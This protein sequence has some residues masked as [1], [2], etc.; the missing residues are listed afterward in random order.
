[1]KSTN[2]PRF[3]RWGLYALAFFLGTFLL[4][5][6]K[7]LPDI[8]TE[9]VIGEPAPRT[10]FSPIHVSFVDEEETARL[11]REKEA[12]VLSVYS[13]D[14]RVEREISSE[15]EKQIGEA[16]LE[17]PE[18]R[19]EVSKAVARLVEKFLKEGVF[20]DSVKEKLS[21]SGT[22]RIELGDSEGR[23]EAPRE[24]KS[25]VTVS[26]ARAKAAALL[27]REGFKDRPVRSTALEI[28][29]KALRPNL[30]FDEAKTKERLKQAADSV[31][32]AA[33]EVK[34]GEMIVQRGLLVTAED[35]ERLRQVRKK[36]AKKQVQSRLV[37]S[38]L[39]IFLGLLVT[40]LYLGQFEPREQNSPAFLALVLTVFGVTLGVEK[41]ALLFPNS[42]VYLLPGAV[43]AILL[44]L[45]RGP[46]LGILGALAVSIFSAPLAEFRIDILLMILLGSLTA[47]FAARGIRKRIQFF[48][49]GLVVGLVN[50]LALAAYSFFQEWEFRE[51]LGITPLGLANGFLVTMLSFF[52]VPL[53]ESLFN[54]TTDITLL[55]LSDLNHPLLK[56]MVVEAP[57][58]YHHSLVV[59][60]LAE[61]ASEA[62]GANALLARVGCYFHDIGKIARSEYFT[63]NQTPQTG[64]KHEKL[65]PS[66][67]S[68]VVMNHVKDGITLARKYKL[69]EVIVRFIPEHQGQGI[70]YYFYRKALDQAAPGEKVN[71]DDFRYPGPKPQSR[72]TAVAL[73]ADSVEAASRSLKEVSPAVIRTLVRKI[74][75]DKFID[76]QLDECDLTLKNL[77]KIQE[78]FVQ[79]LTAI[80]HT[81]VNYPVAQPDPHQPDLFESDQ[82]SKFH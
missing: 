67:S 51:A 81:R 57:G 61:A 9:F 78:S 19:E 60:T 17:K 76:G 13:L 59:S 31:P 69:K 62:I 72:E 39:F 77:H 80:F 20:P 41:A 35:Q 73:L 4:V 50:T 8:K 54:L 18:A 10:V 74:I 16:G 23:A 12:G 38:A 63:E 3:F 6:Q 58:T 52:L 29:S 21:G 47:V 1:M 44:T 26:E 45:L 48:R 2:G 7:S 82:F 36:M 14:P 24:V 68:L 55:E 56:K 30:V 5:V 79:N 66:M 53:L 40:A 64:N 15:T 25:L 46:G 34:R 33:E 49:L 28:F 22:L 11:R 43:A 27:D 70:V 37:S 32:P 42:S 65:T 75:N 71:P